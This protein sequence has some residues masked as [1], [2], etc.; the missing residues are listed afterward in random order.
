MRFEPYPITFREFLPHLLLRAFVLLAALPFAGFGKEQTTALQ[1]GLQ[2]FVV[3]VV[4][5]TVLRVATIL[6]YKLMYKD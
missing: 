6:R 5:L 4:A 3:I 1:E 2:A